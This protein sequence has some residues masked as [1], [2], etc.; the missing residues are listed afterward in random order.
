MPWSINSARNENVEAPGWQGAP[1]E[2]YRVYVSEAQRS[3]PGC[4]GVLIGQYLWTAVLAFKHGVAT[5]DGG[6]TAQ[7][8]RGKSSDWKNAPIRTGRSIHPIQSIATAETSS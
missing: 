1:S 5:L 3:Q 4:N 6:S 2:E 8:A 7:D